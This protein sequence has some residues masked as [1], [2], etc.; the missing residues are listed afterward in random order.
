MRKAILLICI[1][2]CAGPAFGQKAIAPGEAEM[3][4]LNLCMYTAGVR[5]FGIPAS[6]MLTLVK[7][8]CRSQMHNLADAR[9]PPRDPNEKLSLSTPEGSRK[10]REE[11]DNVANEHMVKFAVDYFM[12]DYQKALARQ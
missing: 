6:N 2:A 3:D 1:L 5:L 10:L 4:A 7:N 11:Y 9:K 8:S 12:S